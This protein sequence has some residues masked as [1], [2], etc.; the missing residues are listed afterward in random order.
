MGFTSY[1]HIIQHISEVC[2]P[3]GRGLG[4]PFG[5]GG[6]GW[7]GDGGGGKRGE[8]SARQRVREGDSRE[9]YTSTQRRHC[10]TQ[11][12]EGE[13]REW[14]EGDGRE[15]GIKDIYLAF[16]GRSSSASSAFC[17]SSCF[18]VPPPLLSIYISSSP[19]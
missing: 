11:E 3:C 19:I 15:E 5:C 13:G 9:E 14:E 1:I 18:S 10:K 2:V 16:Y 8:G 4:M 17:V 7:E 12:K 6:W